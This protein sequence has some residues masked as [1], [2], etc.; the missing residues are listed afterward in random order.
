MLSRGFPLIFTQQVDRRLLWKAFSLEI[1]PL[2]F[3]L[4]PPPPLSLPLPHTPTVQSE[5]P[6]QLQRWKEVATGL[7]GVPSQELLVPSQP[8]TRKPSVEPLPRVLH[9]SATAL[10]VL[11]VCLVFGPWDSSLDN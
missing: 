8:H 4:M 10:G 6:C 2:P 1:G 7:T 11:L 5:T 9:F 3:R